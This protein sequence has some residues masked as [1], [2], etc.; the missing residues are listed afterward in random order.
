MTFAAAMTRLVIV[1]FVRTPF[2]AADSSPA[3][4]A[5]DSGALILQGR[6]THSRLDASEVGPILFAQSGIRLP[7]AH[8]TRAFKQIAG[9]TPGAWRAA[10]LA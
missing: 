1:D 8:F 5:P 2:Q 7:G 9:E 4:G 6:L 3:D 10:R